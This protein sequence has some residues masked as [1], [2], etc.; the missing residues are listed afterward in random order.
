MKSGSVLAFVLAVGIHLF[1][2]YQSQHC[3]SKS[4]WREIILNCLNRKT[5]GEEYYSMR[6]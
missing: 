2:Y 6:G 1:F 5:D 3:V 4:P